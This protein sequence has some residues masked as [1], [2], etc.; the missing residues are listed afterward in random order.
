MRLSDSYGRDA[1]SHKDSEKVPNHHDRESDRVAEALEKVNARH[2]ETLK[3]LA[4][5]LVDRCS[6]SGRRSLEACCSD[7]AGPGPSGR[8]IKASELGWLPLYG[9]CNSCKIFPSGSFR[10]AIQPPQCSISGGRMNS[11]PWS[12]R[13]WQMPWMSWTP[14]WGIIR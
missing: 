8:R 9:N 1:V 7:T 10:V 3:Q 12:A 11:T 13:S 2:A 14:R 6:S 5:L 4:G